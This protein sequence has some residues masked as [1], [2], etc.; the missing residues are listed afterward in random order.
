[1][2]STQIGNYGGAVTGSDGSMENMGDRDRR[3]QVQRWEEME[4][5]EGILRCRES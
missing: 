3:W 4:V 2:G 1:M 5:M